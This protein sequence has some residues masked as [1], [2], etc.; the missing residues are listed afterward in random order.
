MTNTES[1]LQSIKHGMILQNLF[2]ETILFFLSLQNYI[3]SKIKFQSFSGTFLGLYNSSNKCHKPNFPS[4]KREKLSCFTFVC[5]GRTASFLWEPGAGKR[6]AW[7]R[8]QGGSGSCGLSDVNVK[9][10]MWHVQEKQ[11]SEIWVLVAGR[12]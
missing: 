5:P 2:K 11:S 8:L 6:V 1:T 12:V 4:P 9:S 7:R 10:V 3:K